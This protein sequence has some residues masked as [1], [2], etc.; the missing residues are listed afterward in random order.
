MTTITNVTLTYNFDHTEGASMDLR[1]LRDA[2]LILLEDTGKASSISSFLSIN[3]VTTNPPPST[4]YTSL[5]DL[6]S[7]PE[8]EATTPEYTPMS[9]L[10][11]GSTTQTDSYSRYSS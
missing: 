9:S 7:E 5:R 2:L 8:V 3:S 6:Y 10:F 11:Q 4:D 1:S